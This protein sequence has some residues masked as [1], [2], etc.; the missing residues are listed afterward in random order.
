MRSFTYPLVG[1]H[2]LSAHLPKVN[3]HIY[4]AYPSQ[5]VL[6]LH[7]KKER[8]LV[9]GRAENAQEVISKARVMLAPIVFGAGIKG[10]FIDAIHSGT[11]SISSSIGAE[12][13]VGQSSWPGYICGSLPQ[14]IQ[15]SVSLYSDPDLWKDKQLLGQELLQQRFDREKWYPKFLD[16]FQGIFNDLNQHRNK[17]F[18]QQVFKHHSAQSTKYMALWIEQKNKEN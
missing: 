13:M 3:L 15:K 17:H 18:L 1:W 7:N 8:F 11:P 14:L 12:S 9:H 4:G 10:K 2:L 16:Y 5:K 6:D